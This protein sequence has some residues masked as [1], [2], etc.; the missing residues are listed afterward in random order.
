MTRPGAWTAGGLAWAGWGREAV[1]GRRRRR[2]GTRPVL[3]HPHTGG[4]RRRARRYGGG[5]AAWGDASAQVLPDS[6]D[7]QAPRLR[8][9][10]AQKSRSV[11]PAPLRRVFAVRVLCRVAAVV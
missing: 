7:F 8:S 9:S 4:P 5:G 6:I 1:P 11:P 10:A 3:R 2:R